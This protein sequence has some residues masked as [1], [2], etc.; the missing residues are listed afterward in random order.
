VNNYGEGRVFVAGD[1]AHI[2]GLIHSYHFHVLA[3]SRLPLSRDEIQ[4]LSSDLAG[5]AKASGLDL[6]THIIAHSL[7][8]RDERNLHPDMMA[9]V[10]PGD[11]SVAFQQMTSERAVC[12][13]QLLLNKDT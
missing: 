3:L 13:V 11:R 1:A 5:L 7:V 10:L 8:G 2:F 9:G 4:T 12:L 6:E